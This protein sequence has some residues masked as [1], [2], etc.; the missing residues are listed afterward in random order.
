MTSQAKKIENFF[1][2]SLN[3]KNIFVSDVRAKNEGEYEYA[4]FFSEKNYSNYTL[5]KSDSED[6]V[7]WKDN[8]EKF[9]F[10]YLVEDPGVYM[11]SDGS[12]TPP[13]CEL[14]EYKET[15][16][17]LLDCI[18]K[19]VNFYFENIVNQSVVDFNIDE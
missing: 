9:G 19:I 17:S 1:R 14:V 5:D 7:I 11:Y 18:K 3:N 6:F 8:N 16:N 4:I 12:G 2:T 13:S 10:S 15:F